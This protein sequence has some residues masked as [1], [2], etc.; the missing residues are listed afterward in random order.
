V[1]RATKG[2]ALYA[3]VVFLIGFV[4]GTIRVLLLA[5]RLGE[6][7]LVVEAPMILTASWFVC[8]RCVDRLDVRRT[9]PAR[10]LMGFVAFLVLMSAEFGMGAVSVDRSWTSLPLM[11]RAPER[12]VSLRRSSLPRSR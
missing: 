4:L 3:I 10:S 8:C 2:G 9:V 5:P 6:S 7:A 12:S 11:E 1:F